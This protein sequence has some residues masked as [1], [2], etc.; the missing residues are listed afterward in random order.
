MALGENIYPHTKKNSKAKPMTTISKNANRQV[1][2]SGVEE[3]HAIIIE[4]ES[5]RSNGIRKWTKTITT[6][7]AEELRK[8]LALTERAAFGK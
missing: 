5:Y 1:L 8:I 4:R 3:G 2:F 6:L 7:T